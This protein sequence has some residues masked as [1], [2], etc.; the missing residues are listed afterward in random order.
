MVKKASP[1]S[2]CFGVRLRQARERMGLPQDKLGVLIGLDEGCSS[3][4]ISRYETGVHQPAFEIA[5]NLAQVLGVCV[6]YFYCEDD[7]L[8]DVVL[9]VGQFD[10]EQRTNLDAWLANEAAQDDELETSKLHP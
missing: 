7:W 5:R 4:R 6:T 1:P 2:C 8:A 9:R 3:A 10:A